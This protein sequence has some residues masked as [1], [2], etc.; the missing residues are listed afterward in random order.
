MVF[1]RTGGT[2]D[3]CTARP[4]AALYG[5]MEISSLRCTP[6]APASVE[7]SPGDVM[8]IMIDWTLIMTSYRIK[9]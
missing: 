6:P 4:P 7:D 5:S 1:V 2:W 8:D 3:S 9:G